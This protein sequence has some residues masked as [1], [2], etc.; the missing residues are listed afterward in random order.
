MPIYL[1][2]VI[3][4]S[5]FKLPGHRERRGLGFKTTSPNGTIYYIIIKVVTIQSNHVDIVH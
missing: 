5:T 4:H 1:A 2:Y 3:K